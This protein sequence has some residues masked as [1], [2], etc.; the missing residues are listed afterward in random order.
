VDD[1]GSGWHVNMLT[2]KFIGNFPRYLNVETMFASDNTKWSV[3]FV[4]RVIDDPAYSY[5]AWLSVCEMGLSNVSRRIL[6]WFSV[7]GQSVVTV[8]LRPNS[9]DLDL[10]FI[11][12]YIILCSNGWTAITIITLYNNNRRVAASLSMCTEHT[13]IFQPFVRR[14]AELYRQFNCIYRYSVPSVISC[15]CCSC[16]CWSIVAI[17]AHRSHGN[18]MFL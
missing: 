7:S 9:F 5:S 13:V 14:Q 15:C 2:L 4:L 3:C 11:D 6:S 1:P 16:C 17:V 10:R 12:C 18:L 8:A